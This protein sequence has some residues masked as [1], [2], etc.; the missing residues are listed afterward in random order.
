[1]TRAQLAGRGIGSVL[2]GVPS[3]EVRMRILLPLS[4]VALAS[5]QPAALAPGAPPVDPLGRELAG[6]IAGAPQSCI[7]TDF[8]QSLRAI[9]SATVGYERGTIL[10]VNRLQQACPALSPYNALVA[11]R[12]GG[13]LCRGDRVRGQEPGAT[14]AGPSCNLQDW[15]P[16]RRR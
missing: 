12:G 3:M 14:I 4:G 10:W 9:D 5:C 16:Y 7:S 6:R 8:S 11:E 1:M 2:P 13:Q 15:V